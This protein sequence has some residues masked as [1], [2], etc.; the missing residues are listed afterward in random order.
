MATVKRTSSQKANKIAEYMET[1]DKAFSNDEVKAFELE[2]LNEVE[3]DTV[4]IHNVSGA[5]FHVPPVSFDPKHVESAD[6]IVFEVNQVLPFNKAQVSTQQFKKCILS[7]KL[8]I[9]SADEANII[10]SKAEKEIRKESKGSKSGVAESGLPKNNK[11]AIMYVF[12]CEDI[13]ELEGY[14][15]LEERDSVVSAIEDRIE[16]LEEQGLAD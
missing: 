12:E 9:V 11:A 1:E 4:F 7:K 13:D 10:R 16:E 3:G 8:K 5:E 6:I 15:E 2:L 14:L